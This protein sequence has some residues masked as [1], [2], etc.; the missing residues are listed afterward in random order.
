ME[1]NISNNSTKIRVIG[2]D[3]NERD[4]DGNIKVNIAYINKGNMTAKEAKE[5]IH[6]VEEYAKQ[7]KLNNLVFIEDDCEDVAM[8]PTEGVRLIFEMT[9]LINEGKTN[10]R[11]ARIIVANMNSVSLYYGNY[12]HVIECSCAVCPKDGSLE[13]LP[14]NKY[15]AKFICLDDEYRFDPQN[16][17]DEKYLDDLIDEFFNY[18]DYNFDEWV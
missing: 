5:Q 3:F 18:I 12:L 6:K 8:Q 14:D 13:L 17:D 15:G 4:A 10:I 9:N 2:N 7:E 1:N 11:I 16:W